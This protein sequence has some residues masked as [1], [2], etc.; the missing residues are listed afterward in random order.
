[1]HS[2]PSHSGHSSHAVSS[3]KSAFESVVDEEAGQSS[4]V[5]HAPVKSLSMPQSAEHSLTQ[6]PHPSLGK[7]GERSS[8]PSIDA[9][10]SSA[11]A[12]QLL[13]MAGAANACTLY[14]AYNRAAG[15]PRQLNW[16]QALTDMSIDGARSVWHA[17]LPH[18]AQSRT[19]FSPPQRAISVWLRRSPVALLMARAQS[20]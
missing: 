12:S 3:Y 4:H 10:Q 20:A 19:R 8:Y 18:I 17:A 9:W 15:Q 6:S 13:A 7:V 2:A 1:M 11:S 14:V 5:L 16:G